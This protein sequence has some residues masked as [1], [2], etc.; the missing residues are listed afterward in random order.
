LLTN[1]YKKSIKKEACW[2]ISNITAGNKEQIQVNQ[3]HLLVTFVS[4][5]ALIQSGRGLGFLQLIHEIFQA[6][7]EANLIGPLVHLLQNAEFDIKKESAWAIS[8]ATSG[9]THEQIK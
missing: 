4:S 7:I 8:N 1:N 3:M 9:G 6:V 5:I 2:T